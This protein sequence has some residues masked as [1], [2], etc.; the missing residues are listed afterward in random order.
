LSIDREPAILGGRPL[1]GRPLQIVRPCFPHLDRFAGAFQEALA[2]GAVTNNGPTVVEFEKRLS[3][4][5]GCLGCEVVACSSGQVA[6]MLMLRAA[7]IDSGEVIVPSYTFSATPHA[8][9]WCGATPI[10]ADIGEDASL[11]LDPVQVERLITERTV[12]ILGVDVYGIACDYEALDALGRKHDLKILYDSA[13]AFGTRV[14]GHPIGAFGNAQ[15]FSFHATKAFTT[16]EGGCIASKDPELLRRARAL[17][18]FGQ[19]SGADCEEPGLNAKMMEV[20]ALIGIEQLKDFDEVVRHRGRVAEQLQRGLRGLPGLSFARVPADQ[21]PVW[22]Y[23]PII[24]DPAKFGL[25]RDELALALQHENIFARKYFE[26][27]CHHLRCYAD[28]P[29]APLP[30][31]ERVAY[32]VLSL[33]VYNDMTEPECEAIVAAIASVQEMADRVRRVLALGERGGSP[34]GRARVSQSRR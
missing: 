22:L 17:R 28:R 3:A 24:I 2:S 13:P 14:G 21:V 25:N 32:N 5:L 9:A 20:C 6:L 15:I 1:C 8:V 11:C 4:Y 33:P 31:T 18:N 34:V 26:L 29:H 19:S 10:F 12:A 7:G 27:P 30:R 16:M 23:F